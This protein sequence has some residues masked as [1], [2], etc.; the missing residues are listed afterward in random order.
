VNTADFVI[1]GLLL[2][3]VLSVAKEEW[4]AYRRRKMAQAYEVDSTFSKNPSDDS[5]SATA[6]EE[7]GK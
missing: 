7:S 6:P 4:L 3:V 5:G 1:I 2:L